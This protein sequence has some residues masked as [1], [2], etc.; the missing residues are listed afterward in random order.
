MNSMP[1]IQNVLKHA[2]RQ[3]SA[4]LLFLLFLALY[5]R[6]SAPSVLSGDSA[7]F[8]M[9]APLLGVPHPTTYPLYV[10]L[11]KL[12]TLVIPFG[13]L[14]WRVTIVSVVCAALAV[15]LFFGIARR[16][17]ASVP[18]ALI[19]ALALGLAPGLWNAATMAEVYALMMALLV[20][21]LYL[22]ADCRLQIADYASETSGQGA[23]G[24]LNLTGDDRRR[25]PSPIRHPP[26][27]IPYLAA[28]VG[29]L[30]FA[31]HGLFVIA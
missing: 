29:G 26:S 11:G 2:V 20:G 4:A 23:A 21:L 3:H 7:E 25:S 22:I 27:P 8:Q 12:A 5:V 19:G 1:G 28:F 13:D 14:A 18:A 24:Q 17:T 16:L 30:G 15:G 6:T 9:A 31:H 10:L